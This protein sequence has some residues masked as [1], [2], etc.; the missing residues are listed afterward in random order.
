MW[1][2][3]AKEIFTKAKSYYKVGGDPGSPEQARLHDLLGGSVV[4][5]FV[6]LGSFATL[7]SVV[8]TFTD[9][10]ERVANESELIKKKLHIVANEINSEKYNASNCKDLREFLKISRDLMV[11]AEVFKDP[12]SR[13]K[14]LKI[15][16]DYNTL[17]HDSK[18]QITCSE[19]LHKLYGSKGEHSHIPNL[20]PLGA[21]VDDTGEA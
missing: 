15:L 12:S 10:L 16:T 3:Y 18:P 19:L 2:K 6:S 20:F 21:C 13:D 4:M 9:G 8:K 17:C 5:F 14:F 7:R 1:A 11:Q